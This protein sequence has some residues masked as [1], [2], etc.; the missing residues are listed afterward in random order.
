[1]DAYC[2]VC[3]RVQWGQWQYLGYGRWR[4]EECTPGSRAWCEKMAQTPVR[5][6]EQEIL[7]T[8]YTTKEA[9]R[10]AASKGV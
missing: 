4:H 9:D 1:M 10:H 3:D 6:S 7:F 5:T 8:W 2:A